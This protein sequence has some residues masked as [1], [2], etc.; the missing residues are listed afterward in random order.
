[1]SP[2]SHTITAKKVIGFNLHSKC[3]WLSSH[4]HWHYHCLLMCFAIAYWFSP[5]V[6]VFPPQPF[7]VYLLSLSSVSVL[8]TKIDIDQT[9]TV[10]ITNLSGFDL[11]VGCS[12]S[13]LACLLQSGELEKVI[14]VIWGFQLFLLKSFFVSFDLR[15][16]ARELSHLRITCKV[17][18]R[19]GCSLSITHTDTSSTHVSCSLTFILYLWFCSDMSLL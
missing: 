18:L 2:Q 7:V 3:V 1:M 16:L 19:H 13:C 14:G 4:L 9:Y 6:F 10:S 8:T 12:C 15:L 11:L 17:Q 5:F